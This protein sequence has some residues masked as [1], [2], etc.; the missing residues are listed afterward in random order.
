MS[1]ST[2]ASG[3]DAFSERSAGVR[4]APRTR[5][6]VA[7]FTC[8]ASVETGAWFVK[9]NGT[10]LLAMRCAESWAWTPHPAIAT[11]DTTSVTMAPNRRRVMR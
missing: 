9:P 1:A 3:V 2:A 10:S 11:L 6:I 5:K 4:L 8:G 7:S